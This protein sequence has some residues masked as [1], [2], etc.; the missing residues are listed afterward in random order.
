MYP[1]VSNAWYNIPMNKSLTK[2]GGF[3]LIELLVVISIIAILTGIIVSNLTASRAKARDAK[4]ISDMGQIQ[5]AL[6]L[7]FDRC[8]TYP[9]ASSNAVD[10]NA[11]CSAS[12]GTV[13][14]KDFIANI[15]APSNQ[16]GQTAYEY[17]VGSPA[18]DYVLKAVLESPNEIIKDGLNNPSLD[19]SCSNVPATKI[20]C[21][22]P[23]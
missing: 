8:R 5:L 1:F 22:G 20:Y 15:P 11:S 19:P 21:I 14:M 9:A 23:K 2:R 12:T 13:Y 10:P 17:H 16:A 6:E 3:T 7:Y 18:T 4:R